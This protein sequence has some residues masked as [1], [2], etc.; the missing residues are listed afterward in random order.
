MGSSGIGSLTTGSL[1]CSSSGLGSCVGS[2]VSWT[3]WVGS[4]CFC[5]SSLGPSLGSSLCSGNGDD[6]GILEAL[7][8]FL[9]CC[10]TCSCNCSNCLLLALLLTTASI[11]SA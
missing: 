8:T 4:A 7:E 10:L 1:N 5:S 11:N 6:K 2:T 3:G 9:I